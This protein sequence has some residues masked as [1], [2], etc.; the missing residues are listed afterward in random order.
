MS[1][2]KISLTSN[3][4]QTLATLTD[5][6]LQKNDLITKDYLAEEI[7]REPGTV[8]NQL[9]SL[10]SLQLVE[11]FP[12]QKGGYKPTESALDLLDIEQIPNPQN[13]QLLHNGEVTDHINVKNIGF[14][15]VHHPECCRAE[16][17]I[18]GSMCDFHE[19]D[20]ISVGPTPLSNLRIT[21]TI[22]AK[23]KTSR[24]LIVYVDDIRAPVYDG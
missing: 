11:S 21:G 6:Y 16:I 19:G 5:L 4:K 20:S 15:T 13:I 9:Q 18:L 12:G 7:N 1:T 14:S 8:R 22:Y 2:E 3:Q 10:T 23:N 24:T 17:R